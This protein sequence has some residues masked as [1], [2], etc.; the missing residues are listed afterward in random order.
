MEPSDGGSC[1]NCHRPLFGCL[2]TEPCVINTRSDLAWPTQ[3]AIC[4]KWLLRTEG[5]LQLREECL[6][7]FVSSLY[8]ELNPCYSVYFCLPCADHSVLTKLACLCHSY[9]MSPGT[10]PLS[11]KF[12]VK[13]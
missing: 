12:H 7:V 3:Q 5:A 4:E 6:L 8:K 1:Y 13:M 10:K 11:E 2:Q 9:V